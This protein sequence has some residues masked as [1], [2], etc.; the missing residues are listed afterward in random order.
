MPSNQHPR[1]PE[2]RAAIQAARVQEGLEKRAAWA[3]K[4][5]VDTSTLQVVEGLRPGNVSDEMMDRVTKVL[6][7]RPGEWRKC[8][9]EGSEPSVDP[10]RNAPDSLLLAELLR[11]ADKRE[12]DSRTG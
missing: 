7:W 10:I 8:L 12:L 6:G 5:A 9:E 4:A 1:W 11:R 3:R 2:L